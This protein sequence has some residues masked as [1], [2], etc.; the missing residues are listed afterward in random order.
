[1]AEN[2]KKQSN[3]SDE[4]ID[5]KSLIG[6]ADGGG[7][8]LDDI[9]SEYGVPPR[10]RPLI[11]EEKRD[12]DGL[13]DDLP[14]PESPR[15][16]VQENRVV[17]FPGGQSVEDQ[18]EEEAEEETAFPEEEETESAGEN[19]EKIIE[20]PEEESAFTALIKD[21]KDRANGYADQM[22]EASEKMDPA[23]I[24]R[25]EKLI[26]GT[27]QEEKPEEKTEKKMD[28]R[29]VR[30][31]RREEA[32]PPDV[33]PQELARDFAKK[34]KGMRLRIV[35]LF[36]LSGLALTPVFVPMFGVVLP[37]PLD[38][39]QLQVFFS[40]ALLAAG[41]LLSVN[42]LKESL[43]RLKEGKMGMDTLTCFACILTLA[44]A[45]VL[46]LMQNRGGQMPY[47]VV[48]LVSLM[49]LSHGEYHK[50]CAQRLSCRT[51][52][53][54]A[55]PYLVT[56]D[57]GKWN[58][59]ATYS[60]WS[61][62][63]VGFGSQIQ[64]DD[65]AQQIY[66]KLCP[67]LAVA[68]VLLSVLACAVHGAWTQIL[69]SLST[70]FLA[71]SALGGSLAYGRPYHKIARRLSKSGAALAGWPGMA[72]SRRGDRLLLTDWDLFPPGYVDFNGIKIFGDHSME[73]VVAY[74][75]TLLRDSGSGLEKLFH[76]QLRMYGGLFRHAEKLT[77]YE[78][79][80]L[81]ALIR[82]NQVLVGSFSF[83][84]LME[85]E[86]PQGLRVKNAVFC[87]IDGE[88]AGVFVLNYSLPDMVFPS[89]SSLLGEK[90]APVLATRDFNIIPSMLQQRFKL[91]ADRMDFPPVQRRRELSDPE[92]SHN[93]TLT[94]VLCREGLAPFAESVVGARRLR[95]SARV[96]AIVSGVGSVLGVLL[97][98]YL[99]SVAAYT[100]LA[101]LNLLIYLVMWLL[102]VWF[103]T[104][105]A[106]RY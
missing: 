46:G 102:P 96:G 25:L 92:Q 63:P 19:E 67:V 1:M 103:L 26:P 68:C 82:G 101:P 65:G 8:S 52:A 17:T 18:P 78:G 37:A 104:D 77:C 70:T 12:D 27:D 23:Q 5:M 89:L 97:C 83:M 28:L 90:V 75:A 66:R 6:D 100:S 7:F 76:D 95:R 106:P 22:F 21:L 32:P 73:R 80:G 40:A 50:R 57:E 84:N 64:M 87:A 53:A 34:I 54:S 71:G 51:A 59:K 16:S 39:Y 33:P 41:I 44:D 56:L 61:G 88:L 60:K 20:F 31:P 99:T 38:H 9:L 11:Q 35:L 30:P 86:L 74:T 3:K 85:V 29:F 43:E 93:A 94:A 48:A 69:W 10:K 36:F 105:W 45:V 24:R 4:L 98:Y 42:V 72:D 49:M 79:G 58:G 62:E 2:D 47:C 14:W 55:R 15:R 13:D 81:S 91:A